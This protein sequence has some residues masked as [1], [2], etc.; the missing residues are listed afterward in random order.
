MSTPMPLRQRSHNSFRP[1]KTAM[2][3]AQRIVGEITDR[4]LPAGTPLPPERDMLEAYGVARG[5]LREALR[6]LEIQ[7]VITIKTGPGGGPIVAKPESRH[8]ASVIAMRLQLTHTPFRAV[9]EARE[10]LEP[11]F[12]RQAAERISDEE[13]AAL[14]ES[15]VRMREQIEDVDAFLSENETFHALVASAAGNE[16]FSL[17]I[18][19]LNWIVDATPLGVEYPRKQREA[20]AK[21]HV[22]I[23]DAIAA[24]DPDAAEAA[25]RA[26]IGDFA[27]YLKKKY[28]D[29]VDAA[30]RWD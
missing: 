18:A 23:A 10:V 5:T 11:A 28:P 22:R 24:R 14:H 12:A 7:G 8:L 1:Q 19:S 4:D 25:M 20:V 26:H 13:I 21:E 27:A 2:L 17:V 9:L 30:L 29:V 6:F 16:F 15:V 3:L